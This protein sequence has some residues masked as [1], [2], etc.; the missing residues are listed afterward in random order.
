[1]FRMAVIR[2]SRHKLNGT[3]LG[4]STTSLARS[5]VGVRVEVGAFR[6]VSRSS[7]VSTYVAFRLSLG[8]GKGFRLH[9][10]LELGLGSGFGLGFGFE[11]GLGFRFVLGFALPWILGGRI[12]FGGKFDA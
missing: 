2:A 5:R 12:T 7:S 9:L 3:V 4:N 1:M 11:F 8:V 10:R 6:S